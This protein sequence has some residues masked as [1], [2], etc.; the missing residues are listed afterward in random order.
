M[1][2]LNLTSDLN[3][4]EAL[5]AAVDDG[6]GHPEQDQLAQLGQSIITEVIDAFANTA[7]EDSLG[8][9]VEGLLGG[10]QSIKIRLERD[11]DRAGDEVKRL[12]RDFD[13]SEIADVELQEATQKARAIEA[14]IQAISIAQE[15]GA[16][17]YTTQTGDIWSPWKGSTRRTASTM[18][19]IDARDAV[20]AKRATQH[21]AVDPGAY[22][23]AFRASPMATTQLDASRVFDAL[24]W[25]L[26][27]WPTMKLATTGAKGPERLAISWAKQKG[28]DVILSTVDFSK[29]GKSA[30]FRANDRMI[31]LDPV[32]TLTL[33]NS[34]DAAVAETAKPFGPA[35]NAGQEAEKKGLR[36]MAIAVKA[37]H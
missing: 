4:F 29:D 33:A 15:G 27:Q 31:A 12:T 34:L 9:I 30:P 14:M 7:M 20:R 3:T 21:N 19:Q 11:W 17:A 36:H 10:F 18:A 22:V 25:A 24:N 37:R 28:V 32:V 6:R 16:E 35:Q 5:C 13:G 23:V 2:N 8:M 1:S 26:T